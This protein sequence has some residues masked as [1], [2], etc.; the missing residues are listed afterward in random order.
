M[1]LLI[2]DDEKLIR[3]GLK[4]MLS[5]YDDIDVVGVAEDGYEALEFCRHNSVD[6]I[7]MD[8][9]MKNCSGVMGTR[10]IMEQFHDIKILILTT[11]KDEEYI[12]EALHYGACGYLLKD[13]SCEVIYEGIKSA[14]TGNIVVHP[15]IA[16]KMIQGIHENNH[17]EDIDDYG[18]TEK[19]INIIKGI[20]EGYSNKEIAEKLYLSEGTIKNNITSILGKLSLRDRT[21]IAIFAFKKGIVT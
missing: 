5:T 18:L 3:E 13:S 20:A 9:R 12:R 10:L 8:V 17:E 21:Q 15:E 19:E 4:I 11:F 6:V 2:V 14:Y 16:S 1:K 7:L